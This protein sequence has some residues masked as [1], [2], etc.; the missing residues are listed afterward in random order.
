MSLAVKQ[1]QQGT[2]TLN[3]V[4]G[5]NGTNFAPQNAGLDAAYDFSGS[6]AGRVITADAGAVHI[7]KTTVD[8]NNAFEVSV[9]AGS[10]A[11]ISVS[12]AG[13]SGSA[14]SLSGGTVTANAPLIS[15]T[16][17]WNNGAVAFTGFFL[18]VTN[19]A[20]TAASKL[21]D[22]QVGGTSKFAV[23][24]L[25][26]IL[27][28]TGPIYI[29]GVPNNVSFGTSAGGARDAIINCSGVGFGQSA[30]TV[31]QITGSGRT[32]ILSTPLLNLSQTWN[33]GGTTF[34]GTIIDITDTASSAGSVVADWRLN[35]SSIM[36]LS[37]L[38][39]LIFS[40]TTAATNTPSLVTNTTRTATSGTQLGNNIR[41]TFTDSGTPST[42]VAIAFQ[43][44][45]TIAYTGPNTG[46]YEALTVDPTVTGAPSGTNLLAAFRLGGSDKFTLTSTGLA[47]FTGTI[48][49]PG[50]GA[51]SEHFGAGSTASQTNSLAVGQGAQAVTAVNT[52]AIGQGAV[53]NGANASALGQNAQATGASSITLGTGS[54]ASA[55]GTTAVGVGALATQTSATA[56]GHGAGAG[57]SFA[58][59]V[60]DSASVTGANS[61]GIGGGAADNGFANCIVLGATAGATAANQL[62]AG[63]PGSEIDTVYIGRGV[64][65]STPAASLLITTT[66][67]VGTDIAA[68]ALIL[69]SGISTGAAAPADCI[70]KTSYP[71]NT[72]T[73]AQ[74]PN[75]RF[76]ARG[77]PITL[78]QGSATEILNIN[79]A[80]NTGRVGLMV[81][82]TVRADDGTD[83]QT[84]TGFISFSAIQKTGTIDTHFANFGTVQSKSTGTLT[85]TPTAVANTNNVSL[86]FNVTS[87]LT[88]T[89]LLCFVEIMNNSDTSPVL[90]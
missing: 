66:G 90:P 18:N 73:T 52:T 8:A 1:L 20:S 46:H 58:I 49:S 87:T 35:S 30:G 61:I 53:A 56:V 9:T 27:L 89:T 3:Q 43:I 72:G 33:A 65:N 15:G 40:Q 55:S 2:A 60:G 74:T 57:A 81:M 82:Y 31:D 10:G 12:V 47:T 77:K 41:D 42:T 22:L 29:S 80:N 19:T 78:T 14:L 54:T 16:Q 68:T 84:E 39:S 50:A 11:G 44:Q 38:G 28:P 64:T 21:I 79:V 4:V 76:Q 67:G 17:T 83:F 51:S 36:E 63:S 26:E 13:G 88:T 37:K 45:P 5:W 25:G 86:K 62:I 24:R 70:I 7:D 6:G 48:T 59:A 85:V 71:L 69:A 75:V 32:V 34:F 23:D